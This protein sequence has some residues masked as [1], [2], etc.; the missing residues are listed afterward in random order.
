M[1]PDEPVEPGDLVRVAGMVA[2]VKK[3]MTTREAELLLHDEYDTA[4]IWPKADVR[5]YMRRWTKDGDERVETDAYTEAKCELQDKQIR[6][7][8]ERI[9]QMGAR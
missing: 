8:Q 3:V 2:I 6:A 4:L 1:K 9:R 5:P 7:R